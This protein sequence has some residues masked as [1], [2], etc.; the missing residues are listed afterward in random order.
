[1][2]CC[3]GRRC[4]CL[5]SLDE[6]GLLCIAETAL[7]RFGEGKQAQ[8]QALKRLVSAADG[9]ARKLLNL[10][11]LALQLAERDIDDAVLEQVLRQSLRRFDKGGDDFYEQISALHKSVRGSDPDASLYWLWSYARW[12]LRPFVHRAS[13]G[14]HGQ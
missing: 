13:R 1:M 4:T 6:A 9:D 7:Q 10:M 3:R 5:Q 12:W 2:H 11:E 8:P 14:A